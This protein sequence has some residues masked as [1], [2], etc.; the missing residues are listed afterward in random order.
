MV[1]WLLKY[2]PMLCVT[3]A[4]W[5]VGVAGMLD[6]GETDKSLQH[7]SRE[8]Q[9]LEVEAGERRQTL[10]DLR[11]Q[12]TA[13]KHALDRLGFQ[14]MTPAAGPIAPEVQ[15][16]EADG[17]VRVAAPD[18]R[19]HLASF[20]TQRQAADAWRRLKQRHKDV[21]RGLEPT[22]QAVDFGPPRGLFLRLIIDVAPDRE[23]CRLLRERGAFC[24]PV[25]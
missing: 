21:L 15:Q 12:L 14:E 6:A 13:A 25:S 24:Q 1:R 22:Y 5:L 17:P 16:P 8:L 19:L 2:V 4:V 20:R 10:S 11:R 7:V 3:A 18:R 23:T 9:A